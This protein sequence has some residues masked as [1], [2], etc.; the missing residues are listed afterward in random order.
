[1]LND[2]IEHA[3]ETTVGSQTPE[4]FVRLSVEDGCESLEQAAADYAK[5]AAW[6][7]GADEELVREAVM[8]KCAGL[9]PA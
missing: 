6:E 2:P 4:E 8:V 5:W 7:C 3:W 9:W 1:M